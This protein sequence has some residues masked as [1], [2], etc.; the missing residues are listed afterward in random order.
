[1]LRGLRRYLVDLRF[2]VSLVLVSPEP[3]DALTAARECFANDTAEVCDVPASSIPSK[4]LINRS[5]TMPFDA[6]SVSMEAKRRA[7]VSTSV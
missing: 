3:T 6:A 5:E 7:R 4:A 1:M 2:G